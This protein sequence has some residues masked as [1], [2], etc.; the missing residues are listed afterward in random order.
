MYTCT[1]CSGLHV[2]TNVLKQKFASLRSTH[3]FTLTWPAYC[4]AKTCCK[5][6]SV[7]RRCTIHMLRN[8]FDFRLQRQLQNN[9][10]CHALA[11]MHILLPTRRFPYIRG[12]SWQ[13][14]KPV[15]IH[16][17]P[18]DAAGAA[19]FEEDVAEVLPD[20]C[21]PADAE[22]LCGTLSQR[23]CIHTVPYTRVTTAH[24]MHADM[25]KVTAPMVNLMHMKDSAA[26][27]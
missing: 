21:A 13:K 5:Q 23:K 4:K 26:K 20:V 22:L 24:Q 3:I 6:C 16:N 14:P 8:I 11:H 27:S 10:S 1:S 2:W 17:S 18:E 25:C 7:I 15:R 12:I 19:A 9:L